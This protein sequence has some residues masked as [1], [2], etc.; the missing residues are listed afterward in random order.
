[1]T[2]HT[3]ND[4]VVNSSHDRGFA[5]MR[6]AAKLADE[7]AYADAITAYRAC[8]SA[9]EESQRPDAIRHIAFAEAEIARLE[10]IQ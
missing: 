2:P 1:V 6:R 8:I 5:H 4:L 7:G 3:A 9:F 10:G